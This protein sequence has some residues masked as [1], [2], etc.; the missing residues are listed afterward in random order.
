MVF[1]ESAIA[2][3]GSK[4]EKRSTDHIDLVSASYGAAG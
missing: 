1:E 3:E 2:R 4:K